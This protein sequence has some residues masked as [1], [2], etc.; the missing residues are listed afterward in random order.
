[1]NEG[2]RGEEAGGQGAGSRGK[3]LL[4]MTNIFPIALSPCPLIPFQRRPDFPNPLCI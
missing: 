1:M 3:K 4:A 2:V